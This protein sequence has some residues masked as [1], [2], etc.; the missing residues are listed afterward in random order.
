[1]NYNQALNIIAVSPKNLRK[2]IAVGAVLH[3]DRNPV[4][5][6]TFRIVS[7]TAVASLATLALAA[8]GN[9]YRPVVA[10][11]NPVGPAGQPTKYAVAISSNGPTAQGL[12]TLVDFSGD[13]I[14][15]TTLI[16]VNP[17]YFQIA[18]TGFEGYTIN[19][20][21][22]LNSFS[23]SSS[24]LFS[25]VL[26]TTLL[27]NSNPISLYQQGAYTY[28]AESGRNAIAQ[29][30]G[31][32]P[33][34]QQE[35]PTGA[36]TVY[37]VGA[38]TSPRAYALV[39]GTNTAAN[40]T[41]VPIE[42][43][44][45]TI[46]SPIAVGIQPVYGVMTAD[47]RRAFIL[48]KGSNTVSVINAQTNALDAFVLN[49]ATLNT[50]PVGVAPIWADFAPTYNEILVANAGNGTTP[51]S[52]T[53][54][55]IAL[56]NANVVN[57]N[58]N[59]NATNPVDAVGFGTVVANIPVGVNPI[60]IT[61]LQ[62][63]TEAFVAN[64]GNPNLPCNTPTTANP[65]PNCSISIINLATNTVVATIPAVASVNEADGYV[66]GRPNWIASTTGTP[67]GKAYVTAGDSTD[68]SII[69]SDN[70]AIQTHLSLQGNGV[71]V[72]VNTQ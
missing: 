34:V 19:G 30:A 9:T 42:T 61:V 41:V 5:A 49:G 38:G 25:D 2:S 67:T 51:G 54:A 63:G 35:L 36:N 64:A 11:I 56:C 39:Q 55:N 22:T 37:T 13:T 68:I 47:S 32:P 7:R 48:N 66:H 70:N 71:A 29:L 26:Q 6:A 21:G 46:D 59:C 40:G 50:I 31:L 28:I 8:C 72:R 15:N 3:S 16:G 69:R 27:P 4:V 43:S 24:L 45:N 58:P 52:V 12:V 53:I 44:S 23:I 10:S 62:D 65:V 18:S 14:V 57:S 33:A 60:M 1:M 20:D 17:Q